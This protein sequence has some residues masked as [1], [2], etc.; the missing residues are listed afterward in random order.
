MSLKARWAGVWPSSS[1]QITTSPVYQTKAR[2]Q[3][4]VLTEIVSHAGAFHPGILPQ[5]VWIRRQVSSGGLSLTSTTSQSYLPS[6][7]T[8]LK[9][10]ATTSF[11]VSS[12]GSRG[13]QS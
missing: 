13:S 9:I 7:S 8:V 3:G 11:R 12:R 4:R 1:R 6:S 5:R 2:H 10:S